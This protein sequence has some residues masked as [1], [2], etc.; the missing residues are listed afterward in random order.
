[1][2]VTQNNLNIAG[3]A[4]AAGGYG[5]VFFPA[6][7]CRGASARTGGVSKLMFKSDAELEY[8]EIGKVKVIIEKI[9]NYKQYFILDDITLCN[10]D[11][12]DEEDLKNL[13]NKCTNLIDHGINR[14]NINSQLQKFKILNIPFGGPDLSKIIYNIKFASEVLLIYY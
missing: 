7:K 3:E 11:V 8:K 2:S 13:N 4:I 14:N 12:L 5:C 1:M 6:I 10:P 9:P